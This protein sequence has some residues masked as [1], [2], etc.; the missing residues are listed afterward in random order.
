M[1]TCVP[2]EAITEAVV[3][4]TSVPE[5][6]AGE[7]IFNPLTPYGV[8]DKVIL[9]APTATV[10]LT[11]AMPSVIT[12][13]AHGLTNGTPVV[14]TTTGALPTGL[15]AATIYFVVNRTTD[16]F[17]LTDTLG[18]LPITTTGS[19]SGTHTATASVHR[20]YESQAATNTG[21][22]PAIDDGTKWIDIGPTNRWAMLDLYR[23]SR[24]WAASPLSLTLTPGRR[25]NS[26][27]LGGMVANS[28]TIEVKVLGVTIY[29]V[30]KDL[31]TRRSY[32]W[33]DF[34]F[35]RF[36]TQQSVL[37]QDLPPQTGASIVMTIT[38]AVGDVGVGSAV[39]GNFVYLGGTQYGAESKARNYSKIDRSFD[40]NL[41][42]P[43][44]RR[45]VPTSAQTIWFEK[46]RTA[47]LMRLRDDLNAGIA[48]WSGLDDDTHDYFEPVLI[49][50]LPT[51][52]DLNLQHPSHGVL[53]AVFEEA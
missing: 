20:T 38:R 8:G 52:F 25:I 33:S 35:K 50:G 23:Q 11:I 46:A 36:S 51:T 48:V 9:G 19:Q 47:D 42:P 5:P 30:T 39:I 14:L 6:S 49:L 45:N 37:L 22:Y 10:T 1:A 32:S 34:F 18:G 29:T 28:V 13:T 7:T 53:T 16:T 3:A 26:V 31:N 40:G 41:V 21:S 2:P 4:S 24:T 17:Q 43:V 27:F 44:R 12:W 15:A